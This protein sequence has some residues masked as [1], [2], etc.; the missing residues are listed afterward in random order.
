LTGRGYAAEIRRAS[1]GVPHIT[2]RD[3]AGL[4]FGV[5]YVQA[6][7]NIC[8]IAEKAV[9]VNAE[10]S[11]Y[12]GVTSATDP[13]VRSDLFFRKAI[14]DRTVER[15]LTGPRDGAPPSQ[16]VPTRSAANRRYNTAA[17]RATERPEVRRQAL[18]T[19]DQ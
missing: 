4:G 12:F 11:R 13:N 9:T 3:F 2:A 17:Q 8:V 14:D 10:R 1:Y 16:E 6:E 19:A 7:D 5:G 18:G 15:L